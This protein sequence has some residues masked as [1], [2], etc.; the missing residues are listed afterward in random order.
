MSE[1]LFPHKDCPTAGT[2]CHAWLFYMA[3]RAIDSGISDEVAIPYITERMS[4]PPAPAMEV[5]HALEAARGGGTTIATT[6]WPSRN[7]KMV[8]E[9]FKLPCPNLYPLPISAEEAI[10]TLFPGNPHDTAR[11]INTALGGCVLR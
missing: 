9:A 2:G 6:K 3:H 11:R 8:Q 10:D 4:R 1:K 7:F 5:E